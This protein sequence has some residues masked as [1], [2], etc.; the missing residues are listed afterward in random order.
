M[1][2]DAS[3]SSSSPRTAKKHQMRV[4]YKAAYE[5]FRESLT[6]FYDAHAPAK[7]EYYFSALDSLR[8]QPARDV[9]VF[10]RSS[11]RSLSVDEVRQN[12]D[13]HDFAYMVAVFALR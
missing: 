12:P 9:V 5:T 7:C 8:C 2:R 13:A 11:S 10:W 6:E 4:A 3:S 1:G